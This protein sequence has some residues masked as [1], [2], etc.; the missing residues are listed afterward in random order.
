[1][2]LLTALT[3]YLWR[4]GGDRQSWLRDE[5]IPGMICLYTILFYGFWPGILAGGAARIIKI[6]YGIPGPGDAGSFLGRLL[7]GNL[8]VRTVG[9]VLYGLMI[10]LFAVIKDHNIG[11][12][13]LFIGINAATGAM[14]QAIGK[15]R[16]SV[17]WTEILTGAGVG[18][19]FLIF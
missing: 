3:A 4:K 10:P 16:R 12:Y 11:G 1:M 19:Y 15:I 13:L 17:F 7:K 8:P 18:T 2:I 5:V 6:G 9:G 14:T